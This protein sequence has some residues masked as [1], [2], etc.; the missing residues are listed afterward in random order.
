MLLIYIYKL[1]INIYIFTLHFL[2]RYYIL[3]H[4]YNLIHTIRLFNL[5][6]HPLI[7]TIIYKNLII[8]NALKVHII[9]SNEGR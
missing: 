7:Y 3:I 4:T 8:N 6:P 1:Y 9:N 5:Y 2:S